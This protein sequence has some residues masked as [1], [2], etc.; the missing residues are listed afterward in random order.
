MSK[1]IFILWSLIETNEI[2]QLI[3]IFDGSLQG[4][5]SSFFSYTKTVYIK[6]R[7][8]IYFLVGQF[9]VI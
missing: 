7:D 6:R 3:F 5:I 1:P 8:I 9:H 4:Y 2:D